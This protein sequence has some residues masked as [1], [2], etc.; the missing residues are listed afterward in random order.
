M[1]NKFACLNAFSIHWEKWE[2]LLMWLGDD[3]GGCRSKSILGTGEATLSVAEP[4]GEGS[5]EV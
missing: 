2:K 5:K 4:A 1:Q 3:V